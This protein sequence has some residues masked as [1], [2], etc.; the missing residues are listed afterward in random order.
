MPSTH[1]ALYFHLVFSTKNLENWN[2]C[3]IR[4]RIHT[5]LGAIVRNQNGFALAAGGINDHVHLLV[6]L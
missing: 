3:E 4:S 5:Y 1:T 2:R 6:S